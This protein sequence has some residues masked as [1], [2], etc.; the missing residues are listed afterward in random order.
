M[1]C[2]INTYPIRPSRCHA[3]PFAVI[4]RSPSLVI[5]S[6]A[7]NLLLS[8]LRLNS[9]TE[10]S[11]FPLRAGSAKHLLLFEQV[12]DKQILRCAQNDR[13]NMFL[14]LQGHDTSGLRRNSAHLSNT[15]DTLREL[16]FWRRLF[17]C[18]FNF[19]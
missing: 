6:A 12:G 16:A 15:C 18:E 4:L 8:V 3:E 1:S 17:Q 11:A 2:P 5:L 13:L 7:K 14:L 9:A 19:K 10:G